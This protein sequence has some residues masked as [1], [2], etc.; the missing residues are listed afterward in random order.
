MSMRTSAEQLAQGIQQLQLDIDNATQK[1]L[2]A[3]LALL[4]K[5][6]AAY[7]L[8]AVRNAHDM[9][10]KHLLD[11]L[12]VL[13]HVPPGR[14]ADI[15]TG[16]GLPGMVLALVQPDRHWLLVDSNGKKTRFLLQLAHEMKVP[17]VQV[18]HARAEAVN[19][20][21]D[22]VWS[23]AFASLSDMVQ[24]TQHLLPEGG[25]WMAM[26]GRRPEEE[27]AALPEQAQVQAI[28][29]LQVPGL[30]EERHLVQMMYKKGNAE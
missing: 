9:V 21:V 15:G 24:M 16:A 1:K 28:T 11:S 27:I 13:P 26:K 3:Y 6:N 23:R 2:L 5:W 18:Q 8:T 17:N 10:Q 12:A 25:L 20:V 22:V 7:N 30:Q 19:T 14:Q 29:A 4:Q